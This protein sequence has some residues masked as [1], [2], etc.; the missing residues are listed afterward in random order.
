MNFGFATRDLG[1][2]VTVPAEQV[3]LSDLRTRRSWVVELAPYQLATVSVTQA[4]RG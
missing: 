4:L 1:E 2:L 3:T